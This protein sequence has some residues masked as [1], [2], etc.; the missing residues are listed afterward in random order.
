METLGRHRPGALNLAFRISRAH[1]GSDQPH[2]GTSSCS[3]LH[4]QGCLKQ[5]LRQDIGECIQ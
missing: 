4:T 2:V 3:G 1:A 5:G